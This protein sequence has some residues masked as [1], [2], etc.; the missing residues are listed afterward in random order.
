MK[1]SGCSIYKSREVG[2]DDQQHP[3]ILCGFLLYKLGSDLLCR[4][5]LARR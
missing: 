1:L 4:K 2:E 3:R 5:V